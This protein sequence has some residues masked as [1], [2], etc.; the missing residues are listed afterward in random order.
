MGVGGKAS[1]KVKAPKVKVGGKASLKV[2]APKVKVGGKASLKVGGKAKVS[3]KKTRRLQAPAAPATPAAPVTPTAAP[4]MET[5]KDGLSLGAY[6]KD[7]DMPA[8]ISGDADQAAPASSNLLKIAFATFA[9][10]LPMF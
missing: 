1:L 10:L 3:V 2:K 4:T 6:T 5:S 8:D 9:M 7:V